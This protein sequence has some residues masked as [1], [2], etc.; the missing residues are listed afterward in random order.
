MD[1]M[2]FFAVA[3]VASSVVL[4]YADESP[5]DPLGDWQAGGDPEGVLRVFLRASIGVDVPLWEGL[6]ISDRELVADCLLAEA[7][8]LVEGRNASC[9]DGLNSALLTMLEALASPGFEPH[10]KVLDMA[11]GG[12]EVFVVEETAVSGDTL[13]SASQEL[14]AV[15]SSDCLVVLVLAPSLLL[16]GGSV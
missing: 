7:V 11:E 6:V 9:F 10:L 5:L 14:P 1:A 8:S 16:Q 13:M 12:T 3:I 15:A 2:V 4:S